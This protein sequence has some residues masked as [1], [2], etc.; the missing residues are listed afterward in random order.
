MWKVAVLLVILGGCSKTLSEKWPSF[1]DGA[2]SDLTPPVPAPVPPNHPADMGRPAVSDLADPA[3]D[4]DPTNSP[5]L[6]PTSTPDMA[7]AVADLADPAADLARAADLA[8]PHTDL[9]HPHD[10]TPE[11]DLAPPPCGRLGEACCPAQKG[12]P[13]GTYLYCFTGTAG[14]LCEAC[15]GTG[16]VACPTYPNCQYPDSEVSGHCVAPTCGIRGLPCCSATACGGGVACC[17]DGSTCSP[18]TDT[19]I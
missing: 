12:A 7:R 10:L 15:G 16:Q 3:A 4:L 8:E 2:T 14:P 5:D 1:S 9:A 11:P 18:Y 19:C 6:T 17:P 13:C